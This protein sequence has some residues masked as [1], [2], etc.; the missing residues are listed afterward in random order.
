MTT[1]QLNI[2]LENNPFKGVEILSILSSLPIF[3]V[4]KESRTMA[5]TVT[6][7]YNGEPEETVV[8]KASMEDDMDITLTIEV[9]CDWFKQECIAIKLTNSD[10]TIGRLIYHPSFDGEKQEFN[11]KYFINF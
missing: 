6:G 11:E 7:T 4:T 10:H 3:N 5:R 1:I 2:G 8:I 9:L